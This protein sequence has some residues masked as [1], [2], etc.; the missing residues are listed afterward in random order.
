MS[1]ESD[2]ISELFHSSAPAFR[3]E[4]I[5]DT[6]EGVI[7][8]VSSVQDRDF[9]TKE[10]VF[11]PDGKPKKMLILT[12]QTSLR[13]SDEDDGLRSI[14][15]RGNIHTAVGK[16]LSEAFRPAKPSS[17]GVLHGTVKLRFDKTEASNKGAP[18]KI[19]RAKFTRGVAPEPEPQTDS[20]SEW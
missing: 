1:E 14:W 8:D 4:K 12:V 3:F 11:W 6:I 19:Y 20:G 13:D 16:A 15:C 18:R 9:V 7:T 17:A 10:P 5:G 2:E